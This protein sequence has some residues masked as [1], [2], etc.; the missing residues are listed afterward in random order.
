MGLLFGLIGQGFALA[1]L[2]STLS[3]VLGILI[4]LF[5][6]LPKQPIVMANKGVVFRFLENVKSRLRTQFNIHSKSSL[7]LIGLL[8]GLLPCGLVYLGIAG[9]ISA[10]SAFNGAL[11]MAAFGFGTFPAMMTITVIRDLITVSFREKIRKA[12]PVFI[13]CMAVL[14]ILRGLNLGIPYISPS[15]EK[16]GNTTQH[17]CCHK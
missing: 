16:I 6:F 7:F 5:M 14:L 17:S 3:V 8:N 13:A 9:S 1:G 11:F 12:M 15:I 10:G 2:Q 4:L